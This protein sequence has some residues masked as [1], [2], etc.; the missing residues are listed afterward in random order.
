MYLFA[1]NGK[2]CAAKSC[3]ILMMAICMADI[4]YARI[5]NGSVDF[6]GWSTLLSV[7]AALYW[8]RAHEKKGGL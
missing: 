7:F 8:G 2:L 3:F 6:G 4:A 5:T 1:N